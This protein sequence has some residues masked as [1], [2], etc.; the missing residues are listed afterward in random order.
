MLTVSHRLI[1]VG[2]PHW[3]FSTWSAT[4]HSGT[5]RF[6]WLKTALSARGLTALPGLRGASR[7]IRISLKPAVFA[8]DD[9]T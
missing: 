7:C 1:V 8:R 9:K 2:T 4:F 3:K 6:I 5:A